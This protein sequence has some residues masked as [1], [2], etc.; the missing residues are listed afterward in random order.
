MLFSERQGTASSLGAWCLKY[1]ECQSTASTW[2]PIPCS[3]HSAPARHTVDASISRT[4]A[5]VTTP[6]ATLAEP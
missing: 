4:K 2:V 3:K 1:L 5:S 6:L